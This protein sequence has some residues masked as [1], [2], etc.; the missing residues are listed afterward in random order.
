MMHCQLEE[1]EWGDI[2]HSQRESRGP[3]VATTT[4]AAN[5]MNSGTASAQALH[6]DGSMPASASA[7]S[8]P[9]PEPVRCDADRGT[10]QPVSAQLT[11]DMELARRLQQEETEREAQLRKRNRDAFL[12]L[13][14]RKPPVSGDRKRRPAGATPNVQTLHHFF[15]T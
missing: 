8:D 9:V 5:T 13:N 1:D 10:S 4:T 3:H 2:M 12:N 14:P 15:R 6:S 7:P 11:S